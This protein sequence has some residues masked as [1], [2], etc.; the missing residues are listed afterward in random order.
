MR[1]LFRLRGLGF[2]WFG[3]LDGPGGLSRWVRLANFW[4]WGLGGWVRAA[5]FGGWAGREAYPT[6]KLSKW[7]IG[8]G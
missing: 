4:K 2:G 1:G 3:G 6:V 8:S 5:A 7:V